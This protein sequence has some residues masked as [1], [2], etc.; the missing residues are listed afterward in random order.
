ML[1]ALFLE[2]KYKRGKITPVYIGG[3]DSRFFNWLDERGKFDQHSELNELLSRMLSAGST[4]E[5]TEV[6]TR[7]S[8]NPQGEIAYGLVLNNT[9]LKGLERKVRD[10]IIAGKTCFI[11]GIKFDSDQ[12]L[13]LGDEAEKEIT[14]FTILELVEIPRFLYEFDK[15]IRELKLDSITPLEDYYPSLDKDRNS[16]IWEDTKRELDNILLGI[17]GDSRNIRPESGFILGLK[18]LLIVLGKRW[19]GT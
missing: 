14:E 17:K 3:K 19:A 9:K 10:P 1:K 12:R 7:L 11:N 15:A 5:D 8:Q 18:A 13:T 6:T 16:K 2:E 4:F